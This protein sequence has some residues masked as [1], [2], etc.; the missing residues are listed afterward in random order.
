MLIR[1]SSNFEE[2]SDDEELSDWGMDDQKYI[3][4]L[5]KSEEKVDQRLIDLYM[6]RV[7]HQKGLQ[8]VFENQ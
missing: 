1:E 5:A 3:D 2:T 8:F 7:A 6:I 4:K